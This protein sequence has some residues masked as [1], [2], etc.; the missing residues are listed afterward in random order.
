M[1]ARR[2]ASSERSARSA[3]GRP[4]RD[5]CNAAIAPSFATLRSVMIVVRSTPASAAAATVVICPLSIRSH[6]SYFCSA[7][8]KRFARRAGLSI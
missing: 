3:L 6:R 2:R 7:D 5:A 4:G 1:S 8:K